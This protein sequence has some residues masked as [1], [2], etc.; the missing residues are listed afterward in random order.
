MRQLVAMAEAQR[1]RD[2]ETFSSL[3]AL[4]ANVNNT[5]KGRTY[6]AAQF[7][8]VAKQDEQRRRVL[9]YSRESLDMA[10]SLFS[11]KGNSK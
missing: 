9:P 10:K 8:P 3:M 1:E 4:I 2:W 7:N 11:T 6:T 5:R